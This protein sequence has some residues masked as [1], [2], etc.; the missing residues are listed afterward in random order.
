MSHNFDE[1]KKEHVRAMEQKEIELLYASNRV[2]DLLSAIEVLEAEKLAL[3]QSLNELLQANIRLRSATILFDKQAQEGN[4]RNE[5]LNK[6]LASI[7]DKLDVAHKVI[8]ASTNLVAP[9]A[10]C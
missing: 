6:E 3:I 9:D 5:E 10:E 1:L 2:K 8:E 4:K 7:K